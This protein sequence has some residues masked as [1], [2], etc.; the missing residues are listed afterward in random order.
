MSV[1][2]VIIAALFIA[3]GM[4]SV[5]AADIA[6]RPYVK[7]P[8]AVDPAYNWTGFYI[9]GH[10]GYSWMNS[11]DT[12][13]PANAF[14]D[15]FFTPPPIIA[16]SLPLDPKGFI[17]GGQAGY[18]WTVSPIWVIGVETDL[19]WLNLEKTLSLPAP[20][21]A[22]RIVTAGEKLDW[23][24]T[25]RG[26][27]GVTPVDRVLV[28][29]TG[30]LAYGHAS[31]STAL[32]RV[33]AGANI[34]VLPGGGGNNCQNGSLSETRF[35]WTAGGGLEWAFIGNWTLK[36]EYLYFD[37]GNISHAMVDSRF[38]AVFNA[39]AELKGN[40]VRAGLNYKFGGSVVAKY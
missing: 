18:N 32:T 9:G 19:S 34:C 3:T 12:L 26:R 20:G 16:A 29:A 1:R 14:A 5:Q 6:V 17:V 4:V 11:T 27:V 15:G 23:F 10:A 35:G 37:L 33:F 31:L 8:A 40:I 36:A 30:G 2:P 13:S 38:P 39:T 25:L 24:G 21:D 22:T 7:A 28:Y